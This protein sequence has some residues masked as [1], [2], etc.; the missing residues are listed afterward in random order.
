VP[1]LLGGCRLGTTVVRVED[2]QPVPGRWISPSAYASFLEG[3]LAEAAGHPTTAAA[4]YQRALDEDPAASEAW[5]RL[6]AVRC[7]ID[8]RGAD[9]AFA[10]ARSVEPTLAAAWLAGAECN[11]ARGDTAKAKSDAEQA[12]RLA[13]KD[14]E[15]T[16]VLAATLAILGDTEGS[17]RLLRGYALLSTARVEP[18]PVPD[19]DAALAAGDEEGIRRSGLRARVPLS[20]VALRAV[21]VGRTHLAETTAERALA[22]EP[23]NADALVALLVARDLL[24]KGDAAIS[25]EALPSARSTLSP[26]GRELMGELLERRVGN[27]AAK[28]FAEAGAP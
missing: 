18:A 26:L 21:R 28:A 1:L 15:V 23:G 14:P 27:A 16:R 25:A 6:G 7:T 2:G 22:A 3:S 24:G 19:L 13:P 17:R 8:R 5:T 9:E 4:H 11:L 12:I 20:H 10:R